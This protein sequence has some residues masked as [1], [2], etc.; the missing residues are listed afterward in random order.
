MSILSKRT[1]TISSRPPRHLHRLQSGWLVEA[2]SRLDRALVADPANEFSIEL[3][4]DAPERPLAWVDRL[5]GTGD[6]FLLQSGKP[7]TNNPAPGFALY[8]P[9]E[10][11]FR[12]NTEAIALGQDD[13]IYQLDP[14]AETM[15]LGAGFPPA[16]PR[17]CR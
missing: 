10:G 6:L 11:L 16:R 7:L 4:E 14:D 5:D 13:A 9:Q 15:A 1:A 17:W 12:E 2:A 3:T 8:A